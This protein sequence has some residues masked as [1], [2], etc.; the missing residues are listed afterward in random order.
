[1]IGSMTLERWVVAGSDDA[2]ERASGKMDLTGTDLDLA[3]DTAGGAIGQIIGIRFTGIGIPGATITK[4]Y[5]QFQNDEVGSA[6]NS[7]LIRG[8]DSRSDFRCD[9]T[10]GQLAFWRSTHSRA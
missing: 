10:T 7:L 5:H 3:D 2:E 4:A 9:P 1:M 6:A 8:Q